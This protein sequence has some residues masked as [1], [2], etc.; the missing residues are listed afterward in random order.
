MY[1]ILCRRVLSRNEWKELKSYCD[2]LNLEFFAT[3]SFEEDIDFLVNIGCKS[4]KIASADVVNLTL[5][6]YVSS[7]D[8]IV[9]VDTGSATLAEIEIAIDTVQ[10]NLNEKIIVHHCPTGHPASFDNV[11]LKIIKTLQVMFPEIPIGF[12][13]HSPGWEMDIAARVLGAALLEKTI[14]EDRAT[15]S[16][17]HVMSLE[18]L[19]A[20][21]FVNSIRNL[22]VALGASRKIATKGSRE[23]ARMIRRS[24][25]LAGSSKAGTSI[26]SCEIEF[27]R[28]GDGIPVQLFELISTAF[29]KNTLPAGHKLQFRDLYW[30]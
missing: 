11:N 23:K 21:Q 15:R 10:D 28:P 1:D 29:L 19:D 6:K 2:D 8:V 13:D 18:R 3:A 16:V 9:Q 27:R 26:S 22:E 7:K 17:E 14:T 30:E 24:I 4:I 25:F 5:L 20:E 12:S